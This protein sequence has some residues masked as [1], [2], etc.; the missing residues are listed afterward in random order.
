MKHVSDQHK[1][2]QST[3]EKLETQLTGT[4]NELSE[5]HDQY[6]S[7]ERD[8]LEQKRIAEQAQE[9]AVERAVA[10]TQSVMQEQLAKLRD[11]KTRLEVQLE[12]LQKDTKK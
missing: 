4:R 8:L 7:L 6:Q 11:E 10:K 3:C 2:L 1:I 12:L 5:I 9:L